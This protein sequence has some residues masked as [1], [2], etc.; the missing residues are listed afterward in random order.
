MPE[1][2]RKRAQRKL[3]NLGVEIRLS[4]RVDG[5]D[6][7]GVTIGEE[8]IAAENV[9]WAA[10][11]H[12]QSVAET[13][14]VELDR[15]GRIVVGSDLAVPGHADVFVVG[16]AA[17]AMDAKTGKPV[18]GVAQG[19]IQTGS[20][21]AGIIKREC[22]DSKP[23]E[24]PTFS[25]HDKGSMAMVGRGYA[26]AAIGKAHYG[27]LLGF[28]TWSLVHVMFLVGFGNKLVVMMG[29][30]WNYLLHSRRARLIIGDRD[31]HIKR[32]RESDPRQSDPKLT[33]DAVGN[34]TFKTESD[35]ASN[36]KH[37]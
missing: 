15:A 9:L 22:A 11:V 19:A 21:V 23:Q 36:D 13:L 32:M 29:W 30:L 37:Q 5:V 12:G 6:S 33:H 34:R 7:E 2:L 26:I 14:G 35:F 8:K 10:G 18:P 20:F 31:I 27:G 24:R 25:Y 1:D 16:D 3:E 4:T 28:L 17:H